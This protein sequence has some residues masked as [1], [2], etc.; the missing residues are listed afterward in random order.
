MKEDGVEH[1]TQP[2][3]AVLVPAE[4]RSNLAGFIQIAQVS[5]ERGHVVGG[6]GQFQHHLAH[7]LAGR[8][9]AEV[10]G[11]VAIQRDDGE[12][13]DNVPVE[14]C[15]LGFLADYEVK[16]SGTKIGQ[17]QSGIRFLDVRILRENCR[18][19]ISQTSRRPPLRQS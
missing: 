8:L 16:D 17:Q 10:D 6:V 2:Q 9:R 4:G 12:L 19:R 1:G 3:A 18:H 14:V 5:G 13:L 11:I 7:N 15:A